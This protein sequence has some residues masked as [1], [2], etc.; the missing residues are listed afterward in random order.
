MQEFKKKMYE[1]KFIQRLDDF[2]L[3]PIVLVG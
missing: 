3:K 2:Q 1:A